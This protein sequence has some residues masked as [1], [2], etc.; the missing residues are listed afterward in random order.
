MIRSFAALG[1]FALCVLAMFACG[2]DDGGT[3]PDGN[4]DG[5]GTNGGN[6]GGTNGNNPDGTKSPNVTVTLT[7]SSRADVEV[8]FQYADG[9]IETKRT[10]D[11]GKATSTGKTAPTMATALLTVADTLTPF[12]WV[13]AAAGDVLTLST[14][15]DTNNSIPVAS[16][17]ITAEPPT[18]AAVDK[19]RFSAATN[20]FADQNFVA[21]TQP[22]AFPFDIYPDCVASNGKLTLLGKEFEGS[23]VVGFTFQKDLGVPNESGFP[24]TLG[25]WAAPATMTLSLANAG[26]TSVSLAQLDEIVGTRIVNHQSQSIAMPTTTAA[27]PIAAGFADA[28]QGTVTIAGAGKGQ[29]QQWTTRQSSTATMA[30][31]AANTLAWIDNVTVTGN[32]SEPDFTWTGDTTST[33][34]GGLQFDYQPSDSGMHGSWTLLV[35]PGT[36]TVHLPKLPDDAP[37]FHPR[38]GLGDFHVE[39]IT[40]FSVLG[41]T[42]AQLRANLGT[43]DSLTSNLTTVMSEAPLS[44]DGTVRATSYAPQ[45]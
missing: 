5:N 26:D 19:Y 16:Y 30:F 10:A 31:D 41:L 24:L 20:C 18:S 23:T 44:A 2:G 17:S 25:A 40:F 36:T 15:I 37:T 11:D 32:A 43:F 14:G 22:K 39:S 9:T 7:G 8:V 45:D 12:T 42:P 3:S 6:G 33:A 4:G 28:Y 13:G 38:A 34:G 27:F 35:P 21:G 29:Q 1:P